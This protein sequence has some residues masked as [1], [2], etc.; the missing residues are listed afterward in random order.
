VYDPSTGRL[1]PAPEP[2]EAAVVRELF[3]RIT[4]GHSFHG[5]A[6][7]FAARGLGRRNGK[8]FSPAHLR[9]VATGDVYR[10]KR[11]HIAGRKNGNRNGAGSAEF[12]DGQWPALVPERT[13]HGVQ[14]IL[15]DPARKTT[16]GGRAKHLL[17]MIGA[18]DVCGG[19]LA[20]TYR[21]GPREYVCHR[22]SCIRVAADEVDALAEAAMLGYLSRPDNVERLTRD[23]RDDA[24]LA[25]V[26]DEIAAIRAELD[27]LADQLGRGELSATLAARAEPA[28]LARLRAA[29][30]REAE[31]ST[32]EALRGLMA[33]GQNVAD[34]WEAAPIS[35][36]R[37]VAR[38][39]LAP[40]VLGELRVTRY[41]SRG[42]KVPAADRI[43][44]RRDDS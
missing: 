35:A 41:P 13:W 2:G 9:S 40:D 32:P 1:G 27:D 16:R 15:S 4:Q 25:E 30:G 18:C 21:R 38:L 37:E 20:A 5:I 10:G 28:I 34:R 43:T 8:P 11:I 14:R 23:D 6:R 24:D 33:P 26:R 29:E 7:D 39:L 31:L 17:S 22:R 19:P 3:E 42:H 44:W 12:V 36:K